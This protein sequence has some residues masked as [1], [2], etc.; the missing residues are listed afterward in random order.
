MNRIQL[1]A[2]SVAALQT[3]AVSAAPTPAPSAGTKNTVYS[4][5]VTGQ[6]SS[7]GWQLCNTTDGSDERCYTEHFDIVS[8]PMTQIIGNRVTMTSKQVR[9]GYSIEVKGDIVT[10]T[11]ADEFH[12]RS[13]FTVQGKLGEKIKVRDI[14]EV[15]VQ[16]GPIPELTD[17]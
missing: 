9:T 16:A 15:I 14:C 12:S 4:Y 10:A 13:R 7:E 1:F 8:V 17:K 11:C 3:F 6:I 2:L 5:V